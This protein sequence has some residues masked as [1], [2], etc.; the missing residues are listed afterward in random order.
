MLLFDTVTAL[1]QVHNVLP[2]APPWCVWDE[3]C[4]ALGPGW[5][6]GVLLPRWPVIFPVR[7]Q[8]VLRGISAAQ[9]PG[10]MFAWA[11]HLLGCCRR[12]PAVGFGIAT[13][14]SC[15]LV[16]VYLKNAF[17]YSL[18]LAEKHPFSSLCPANLCCR[19]QKSAWRNFC[20]VTLKDS[21]GIDDA[22]EVS[23]SV[24]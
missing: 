15:A 13:R 12:P 9:I 20:R 10:E 7:R 5:H 11:Q 3:G 14:P 24:F 23:F 6:E 18:N 16:A 2:K 8:R 19:L 1:F 21:P 22:G 4:S 17:R